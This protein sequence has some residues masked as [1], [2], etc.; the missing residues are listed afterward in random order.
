MHQN[1]LNPYETT[2]RSILCYGVSAWV[3]SSKK[4]I[5]KYKVFEPRILRH[6]ETFSKN[7]GKKDESK[8]EMHRYEQ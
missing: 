6:C 5:E 1:Q 4:V 3:T 2:I 7:V 8:A